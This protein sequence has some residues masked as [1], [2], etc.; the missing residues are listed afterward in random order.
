MLSQPGAADGDVLDIAIG[1]DG[2]WQKQ[3]ETL[4]SLT[5][6]G[7]AIGVKSKGAAR[8]STR[9]KKY[10][11]AKRHDTEPVPHDCR[12]NWLS[13]T[14]EP[15]MAAQLAKEVS[16][17]QLRLATVIGDDESSTIKKLR[18]EVNS[19]LVKWSDITHAKCSVGSHLYAIKKVA[20][21]VDSQCHQVL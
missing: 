12:L 7:N 8:Y 18:E 10:N 21:R 14:M 1:C 20:Q 17:S 19:S 2:A 11:A 3:G 15:G 6:V 4:N 13:K 16:N 9:N 5:G